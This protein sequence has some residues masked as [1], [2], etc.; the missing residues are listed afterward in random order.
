MY[1]SIKIEINYVDDPDKHYKHT[2]TLF[3]HTAKLYAISVQ[4]ERQHVIKE[5]ACQV[6]NS[7][8]SFRHIW[9][10]HN[11]QKKALQTTN[12]YPKN[13]MITPTRAEKMTQ[14]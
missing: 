4:V 2:K 5:S 12:R 10:H 1:H 9:H 7:G 6:R 8:I 14:T 13:N 3:T 11:Q